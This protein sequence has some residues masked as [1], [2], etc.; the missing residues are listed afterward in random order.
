MPKVD[1]GGDL[2]PPALPVDCPLSEPQLRERIEQGI[3]P[4]TAAEYLARGR[5]EES[6]LVCKPKAK[7]L[8]RHIRRST[9]SHSD[10]PSGL[11]SLIS[12]IPPAPAGLAPPLLW[13][14]SVVRQFAE[15]RLYVRRWRERDVDLSKTSS[16]C[17][18]PRRSDAQGWEAFMLGKRTSSPPLLRTCLRFD[19]VLV[20]NVLGFQNDALRSVSS[21]DGELR[22]SWMRMRQLCV[23]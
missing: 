20:N 6:D 1:Q 2:M 22:E 5:L 21:S 19:Q 18:L 11:A 9:K 16:Q 15:L 4:S 8:N 3:P 7:T 12:R 23:C 17:P 10:S 14:E 13:D